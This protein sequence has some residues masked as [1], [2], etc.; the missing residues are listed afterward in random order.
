MYSQTLEDCRRHN[1]HSESS[2]NSVKSEVVTQYVETLED[3][4]G[5]SGTQPKAIECVVLTGFGQNLGDSSGLSVRE[6][7]DNTMC[8][9]DRQYTD[10]RR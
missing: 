8:G 5:H 9:T 6:P 7:R 1:G 10:C 3:S 4:S 2:Q